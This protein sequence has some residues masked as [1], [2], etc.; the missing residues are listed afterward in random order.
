MKGFHSSMT[1]LRVSE[2]KTSPRLGA[3]T[4]AENNHEVNDYGL[5]KAI[6]THL[7][8]R[9]K[10]K[11]VQVYSDSASHCQSLEKLQLLHREKNDEIKRYIY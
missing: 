7:Q 4:L 6:S 2:A 11:K 1:T 10:K 9:K 3:R 5:S 8:R